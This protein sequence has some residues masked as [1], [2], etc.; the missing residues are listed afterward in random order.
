MLLRKR[1][2]AKYDRTAAKY[3]AEKNINATVQHKYAGSFS[4]F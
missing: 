3:D 1:T 4:P 2:A